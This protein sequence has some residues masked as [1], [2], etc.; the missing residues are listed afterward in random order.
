[1][2]EPYEPRQ[3]SALGLWPAGPL[4]LKAYGIA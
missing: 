1:M 2:T 3:V 4:R